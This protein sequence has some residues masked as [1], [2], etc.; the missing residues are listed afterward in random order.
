MAQRGETGTSAA[1]GGDGRVGRFNAPVTVPQMLMRLVSLLLRPTP[2][3]L[4][5]GF[6]VAAS[7]P[8]GG[9][10]LG[11][12]A[13]TYRPDEPLWR[14]L[15]TRRLTRL[16]GMGLRA[17]GGDVAGQCPG[18]RLLPYATR[19]RY[20]DQG[21]GLGGNWGLPGRCAVGQPSRGSGPITRR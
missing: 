16:N 13:K 17:V 1:P 4:A 8:R 9:A 11:V 20:P 14:D 2:G 3:S 10:P 5:V 19:E 12:C 21:P 18:L 15:P 7:L 6:L